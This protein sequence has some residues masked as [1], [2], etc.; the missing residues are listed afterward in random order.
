MK[1]E[2]EKRKEE[3]KGGKKK[4]RK[5]NE[6]KKI[7]ERKKETG[8]KKIRKNINLVQVESLTFNLRQLCFN[9]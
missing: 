8:E 2:G 9:H 1:E 5:E 3:N 4:E 7:K 6:G